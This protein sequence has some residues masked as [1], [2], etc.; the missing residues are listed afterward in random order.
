MQYCCNAEGATYADAL[1]SIG[2]PDATHTWAFLIDVFVLCINT[3]I[4]YEAVISLRVCRLLTRDCPQAMRSL[5]G[6]IETPP[7][8]F[9]TEVA[10]SILPTTGGGEPG[11]IA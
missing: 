10:C 9:D 4:S 7:E 3:Y 11:D 5:E 1:R 6:L 2:C 8:V